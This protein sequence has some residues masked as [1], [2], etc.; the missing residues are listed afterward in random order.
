MRLLIP[1]ALIGL[2]AAAPSGEPEDLIRRANAAFLAGDAEAADSLYAAAEERTG[3]PGLVSF[4]KAAILFQ[5]GEFY[6]AEVHYARTLDD[7]ACPPPRAARAWFNRGTCLLRRG[8]SPSVFRS[9]IACFDRCLDSNILDEPLKADARHNLELAKLL[10]A[11]ANK[12]A[13]K[14]ETPNAPT[15]EERKPEPPVPQTGLDPGQTGNDDGTRGLL[16]NDPDGPGDGSGQRSQRAA[17]PRDPWRPACRGA[18]DP[19]R[20]PRAL[21]IA[22]QGAGSRVSQ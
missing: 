19:L 15:F 1:F 6:A 18:S 10:W 14:P 22:G 7:S 2:I 11:E 16:R 20:P 9:A 21:F 17:R 13:A 5:K 12:K 8:G 3:D 4:N